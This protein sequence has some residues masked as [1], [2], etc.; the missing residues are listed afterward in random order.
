MF[1]ILAVIVHAIFDDKGKVVECLPIL[2]SGHDKPA[3]IYFVC[4]F[5]VYFSFLSGEM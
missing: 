1:F 5:L 4:K 3:T 2:S